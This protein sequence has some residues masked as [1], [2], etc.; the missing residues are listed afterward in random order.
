MRAIVLAKPGHSHKEKKWTVNLFSTPV[1]FHVLCFSSL[2][3]E[4]PV[5]IIFKSSDCLY[6]S[7]SENVWITVILSHLLIV[8]E[9]ISF[10]GEPSFHS[11]LSLWMFYNCSS[12]INGQTG[13][14]SQEGRCLNWNT[15]KTFLM[16]GS[17]LTSL[18]VVNIY[19]SLHTGH[20]YWCL[21]AI[22]RHS[23]SSENA[24]LRNT[25]QC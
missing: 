11:R 5:L 25:H 15:V 19:V 4:L 17:I 2:F 10:L 8:Y 23:S 16:W 24:V 12:Q 6:G 22:F 9:R 3:R 13:V 20:K 14:C 18:N 1:A 21:K 7:N